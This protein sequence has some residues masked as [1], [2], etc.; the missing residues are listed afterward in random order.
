V[1]SRFVRGVISGVANKINASYLERSKEED[2]QNNNTD[3]KLNG[4]CT[5]SIVSRCES[6]KASV[7]VV[8]HFR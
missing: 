7:D 5:A 1:T 4:S 6:T 8:S 3:G 2:K